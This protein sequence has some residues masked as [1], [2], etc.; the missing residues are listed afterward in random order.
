MEQIRVNNHRTLLAFILPLILYLLTVAPTISSYDSAELTTAAATVGLTRPTGYPLYILLGHLWSRIPVGDIGFRLNLFSAF[1]GALTIALVER[2]FRR[3]QLSTW[4]TI[5]ALGLLACS[6]FFWAMSLTAEVYTLH[7]A[8]VAAVILSLLRWSDQPT[9]R[10]LSIVGLLFG[11]SLGNHGAMI[12]LFPSIIFIIVTRNVN[13]KRLLRTG[14]IYSVFM[15]LGLCIYLYLPLRYATDPIFNYAGS[16]N[17]SGEFIP[18]N[19][20]SIKSLFEYVTGGTFKQL[21]FAIN[22][23]NILNEISQFS[24][25]IWSAFFGIGIGPGLLGLIILIKTRWKFGVTTLLFFICHAIF[26]TTY[27]VVDKETMLLPNLLI[28]CIWLGVGYESLLQFLRQDRIGQKARTSEWV[29]RSIMIV[30]VIFALLWNFSL[31][32]LSNDWSSREL[33]EEILRELDPNAIIIG[34]WETIPTIEYLQKVEDQRPDVLAVNRFL[35]SS[36]DL[37]K[38]IHQEIR[39]RPI[40][41]DTLPINLPQSITPIQNGTLF[42]LASNQ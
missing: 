14:L 31:V 16:Y 11:L 39:N 19:L 4:S 41:T 3:L 37:S 2:V 25:Y 10:R 22:E 9:I 17:S 33:G 38:L 32:D 28:W 1:T 26:Y 23:L 40:Y 18:T 7:T 13:G 20:K 24:V 15:I 35:I 27:K 6:V 42:R 12:L 36:N 34:N 29:V 5:G 30:A 21:M 8:F